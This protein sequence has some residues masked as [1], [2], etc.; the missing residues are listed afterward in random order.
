MFYNA[1][2]SALN[3]ETDVNFNRIYATFIE[4]TN[5]ELGFLP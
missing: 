1:K 3:L 4:K 5:F 2:K